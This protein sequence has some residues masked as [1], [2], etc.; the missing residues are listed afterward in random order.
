[1]QAD[2]AGRGDHRRHAR[3]RAA[4]TSCRARSCSRT[5]SRTCRSASTSPSSTPASAARRRALALRDGE[6]RL[7]VGPDNGLLL[8][9]AER[10][11]GV[12]EA[13]ELA[14][15]AY[16]LE[17]CRARSTAATS[18]RRPRRTSPRGVALAELGP[19]RRPRGARA[20]STSRSRRSAHD[21]IRATVLAVDRF[22]NVA[23]QPRPR[24]TWTQCGARPAARGV[25]LAAA[26]SATTPSRRAPSRDAAAGRHHPLRGRV[27][28]HLARD[29]RRQRRARCSASRRAARSSGSYL[30]RAGDTSA[31]ASR[32]WRPNA[33]VRWP[34][35][36]RRLPRPH[37][38]SSSTRS[39]PTWERDA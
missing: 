13:H 25:E 27:P 30:E 8:P 29:Q 19:P 3:D 4:G 23:A 28:E 7:F 35:L 15:P 36:W 10:F 39:R 17:R 14:N 38:A 1:M 31:S 5:R 2:R 12:A 22:G 32:A 21:R 11:G 34:R 20:R 24:R 26:A 18:S 6:G 37:A 16:A 33:V 9:A